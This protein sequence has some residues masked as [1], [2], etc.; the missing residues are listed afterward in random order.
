L[1]VLAVYFLIMLSYSIGLK[2]VPLLDV[3][4]LSSGYALRVLAGGFATDIRVSPWLLAFCVCLFFSLALTKRY[5]ELL[6]TDVVRAG[7][8]ERRTRGYHSG[9]KAVILAQGIASAYVAVLILALYTIT[10]VLQQL[11]ARHGLFW[12]LCALLFY[13][14]NYL[15]LMT[16]RGRMPHDQVVFVFKDRI[17]RL[18]LIGMGM[19]A[20]LAL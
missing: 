16:A 6:L 18:L 20:A 14:T 7:R 12:V 5:S 2:D 15:W 8:P 1:S 19:A 3:L 4:M 9:D 17:S 11:H 13:W 10:G